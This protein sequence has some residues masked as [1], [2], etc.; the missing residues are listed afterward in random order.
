MATRPI[1]VR[2]RTA[3]VLTLAIASLTLIALAPS[4]AHADPNPT[5]E[6]VEAKV[7]QL[8]R[9]AEQ[10]AEAYNAAQIA[11]DEGRRKL[12]QLNATAAEQ[13]TK[14]KS[15]QSTMSGFAAAAYKAGGIDPSVSLFLADN[16]SD[17]LAQAAALDGV[18]RRQADVF[19]NVSVARQRLAQDRAVA[20]QQQVKLQAAQQELATQKSAVEAKL[21]EQQQVL[22]GLKAE[23]RRQLELRRQQQAAASAERARQAQ[24][25]TRSRVAAPIAAKTP[26]VVPVDAAPASGRAAGAVAFALSQVGKPY[27]YGAS[28]PNAYDC[29]GL[30]MAAYASVGVSLPHHS[31]SQYASTR[32]ISRGELQPGDLVFYYSP[33]SH[34]AMY[35]GGGMIVHATTYGKPVTVAS[36]DFGRMVGASRP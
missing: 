33:I 6:Q 2:T 18:S 1:R 25:A 34:V 8:G 27:R 24:A 30:T 5:I 23:Q 15:L 10:A 35:I 31:G 32:R 19:R 11:L 17:F 9:E 7:D 36:L 4:L 13:E 26:A 28:G 22:D 16:P 14:V 3:R 20:D 29:S 12:D 21:A